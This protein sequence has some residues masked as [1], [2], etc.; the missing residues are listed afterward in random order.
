MTW[1]SLTTAGKLVLLGALLLSALVA[2]AQDGQP[3]LKTGVGPKL[4]EPTELQSL[5]LQVKQKDALLARNLLEQAQGNFQKALDAL[6]DEGDRVK[7]ENGWKDAQFDPSTL[8]FAVP[9][10][11]PA[12][13]EGKP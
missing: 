2:L 12:K 1:G 10:A 6:K 4:L 5:R 9:A 3:T 11:P 13:K 7:A 8:Q